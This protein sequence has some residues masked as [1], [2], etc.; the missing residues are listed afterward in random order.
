MRKNEERNISLESNDFAENFTRY[1]AAV[2]AGI[3]ALL[4]SFFIVESFVS[5]DLSVYNSIL[6]PQT[7]ESCLPENDLVAYAA[8][9][10]LFPVCY[11]LFMHL[12]RRMFSGASLL[13][14]AKF[15][16]TVNFLW[17]AVVSFAALVFVAIMYIHPEYADRYFYGR[18]K[19]FLV[20]ICAAFLF[21]LSYAHSCGRFRTLNEIFSIVIG[22]SFLWFV[23]YVMSNYN[24]MYSYSSYN[25]HHYSAWWFPIYKVGSGLTLGDGFNELYGF[26]PYLIV[27]VL[28]LF[29]GVNQESISLYISIIFTVM[30]ACLLGFC[31]RFFKNKL[32]GTFCAIGFFAIGPMIRMCNSE[33]Y[34]QYYPAR[35][36]FVFIA[37]GFIALYCSVSRFRG[38]LIVG[39]TVMCALALVW[40]TESG[41]VTTIIW[42][43]FL[44]LDKAIDHRLNSREFWKRVLLAV[45][46]SVLSVV[47]FVAIIEII[48]YIRAGMLLSA[49]DILFGIVTFSDMGFFMLPLKPGIWFAVA[50]ALVYGLFV[51]VPSLAF[52][53]KK[54]DA[55][56]QD[57]DFTVAMFM[58][59][60]AGIGSFMYFMGRSFPTNCMTFMSWP[61]LISMLLA[62]RNIISFSQLIAQ[63]K[64]TK[65]KIPLAKFS[66]CFLRNIACF[67]VAGVSLCGAI[68]MTVN[69]FDSES[70]VN[71]RYNTEQ[72]AFSQAAAQIKKWSEEECGGETPY[73][74]HTYGAFIQ[75]IMGVPSRENV[76]EQ[77]NW[78]RY[79]DA[80]TYIDFINSH[81]ASPFVIDESAVENLK[82]LFPAEWELIEQMYDRRAAASFRHYIAEDKVYPCYL[83][84]PKMD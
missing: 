22:I 28:K 35:A 7:L 49:D 72:P 33:L 65:S 43:G 2:L 16:N 66:G 6:L 45:T 77:I 5:P 56:V 52:A 71:T 51:S 32:L 82:K 39:G 54:D 62:D 15:G 27:P 58:S 19:V 25:I 53:K 1:T 9:V 31:N 50:F 59:S 11:V 29:G 64:K 47:I 78:F 48:T 37:L 75:E 23:L 70:K 80:H 69:A 17:S 40:N 42:A 79:S 38:L 84:V 20:I 18:N 44:I 3:I 81:S 34:F 68:V 63:R 21:I 14:C 4:I 41:L 76:Y 13:A 74:L 61:V 36:L 10:V 30:A 55:S 26:Y 83:Y 8:F 73:I 12:F 24:Y 60:V 57:R 46:S 67:A